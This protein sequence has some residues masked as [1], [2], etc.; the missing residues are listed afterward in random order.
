MNKRRFGLPAF[1]ESSRSGCDVADVGGP[2]LR[3]AKARMLRPSASCAP[4]YVHTGVVVAE[5]TLRGAAGPQLTPARAV[6][7]QA[8]ARV[9]GLLPQNRPHGGRQ[10]AAAPWRRAATRRTA[11]GKPLRSAAGRCNKARDRQNTLRSRTIDLTGRSAG[12]SLLLRRPAVLT[13]VRAPQASPRNKA[14]NNRACP[15]PPLHATTGRVGLLL[16]SSTHMPARQPSAVGYGPKKRGR[17]ADRPLLLRS[18]RPSEAV[19]EGHG[20]LVALEVG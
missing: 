6:P 5:S 8:A 11:R 17:C 7:L 9:Q 10:P 1:A 16:P 18:C 3:R 15:S 13:N 12:R 2:Q 4:S 20:H 19:T 14:R